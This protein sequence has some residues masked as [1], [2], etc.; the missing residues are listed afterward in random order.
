MGALLRAVL[1]RKSFP[2]GGISRG[3]GAQHRRVDRN[4]RQAPLPILRR[5]S[6]SRF[7]FLV[8]PF[9][10]FLFLLATRFFIC[11]PDEEM[12]ER[13]RRPGACEAPV[14]ACHDRHAG[15]CQAPCVPSDGTLAS[16]RSTVA[17]F[18]PGPCSPLS[19]IPSRIVRR[20]CSTHGS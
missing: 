6:L 13:R 16:R 5:I 19:G 15:A 7:S 17:I 2:R 8:S 12:A 18:D 11:H 3:H 4:I 14:S 1:T 10:P 20:P 9:P